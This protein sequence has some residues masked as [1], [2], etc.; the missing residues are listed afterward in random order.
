MI[1]RRSEP[2]TGERREQRA[3]A[4][5]GLGAKVSSGSAATPAMAHAQRHG[6]A[7][8]GRLGQFRCGSGRIWRRATPP[9]SL[10]Q[11]GKRWRLEYAPQ[12]EIAAAQCAGDAATDPEPGTPR[13]I[14]CSR[15]ESEARECPAR[16][17]APTAARKPADHRCRPASASCA[18]DSCWRDAPSAR[19][20]PARAHVHPCSTPAPSTAPERPR[21]REQKRNS[22]RR[23]HLVDDG[24]HL[25]EHRRRVR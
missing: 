3:L 25:A 2:R 6:Q 14:P 24:L 10:T 7:K 22:N 11:G 15:I 1:S 8:A 4:R 13:A 5:L 23:D 18:R 20:S 17:L 21:Q 19:S 9:S 12:T 16:A